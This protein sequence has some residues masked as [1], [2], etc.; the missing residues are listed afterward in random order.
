[1]Q[2]SFFLSPCSMSSNSDFEP[3]A[4]APPGGGWGCQNRLGSVYTSC[5]LKKDT[6]VQ[7][8]WYDLSICAFSWIGRI[9]PKNRIRVSSKQQKEGFSTLYSGFR[10]K[11]VYDILM[12]SPILRPSTAPYRAASTLHNLRVGVAPRPIPLEVKNGHFHGHNDSRR[13]TGAR[14]PG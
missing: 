1:M 8:Y 6:Q 12:V 2:L 3:T 14:V 7:T 4:C 5:V 13:S 11:R 10:Q 9:G